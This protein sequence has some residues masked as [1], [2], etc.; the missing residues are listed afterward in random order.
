HDALHFRETGPLERGH[1]R[2]TFPL[3]TS[4]TSRATLLTR[5]SRITAAILTL[6]ATLATATAAPRFAVVRVTDVYRDLPSTAA[7]QERTKQDRENL[8][9]NPR[10]EQLRKALTELRDIQ[11][12]LQDSQN[13]GNEETRM[14][15]MR[16]F[17]IKRQETHTIQLE[18]ETFRAAE[19]KEINRRMVKAMRD[20]LDKIL[21][22]SQEMAIE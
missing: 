11:L 9:Q 1:R 22:R 17:E 5:M 10:A 16:E 20:S 7:L 3:S 2:M 21:A 8:L 12:K 15:L 13:S 6:A 14:Q 18:F 4:H 19:E